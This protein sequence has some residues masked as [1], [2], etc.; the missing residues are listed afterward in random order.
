MESLKDF[1]T[2]RDA[3]GYRLAWMSKAGGKAFWISRPG[4]WLEKYEVE[5]SSPLNISTTEYWGEKRVARAGVYIT[6]QRQ[7]LNTRKR[8]ELWQGEIVRPFNSDHVVSLNL[9]R[10]GNTVRDWLDFTNK[11]GLIG[12][13]PTLGR[14]FLSGKD[15]R[16]FIAETEHEGE[17]HH[18]RNVLFRVYEYYPAIQNRDFAFL[19]NFITWE[20]DDI[21]RE[22]IG[23][24]VGGIKITPAIAMR[25][26][27][28]MNARYFEVMSKPDVF[29]P[30]AIAIKDYVNSYL[31]K[32]LSLEISFDPKT[33]QFIS[34]LQFGSFGAALVA[35][36]V[37]LVAGRLE[38]RACNV[39]GTWFRVGANHKRKDR[40]F[41]SPACKMRDYR[42]RKS[43]NAAL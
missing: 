12:R 7:W 6:G 25:E 1:E 13:S 15:K 20:S 35:E 18:L 26:K 33:L 2:V 29:V 41:C 17:W 4:D 23:L 40:I 34:S 16:T 43:A 9:L 38:A 37:E 8:D 10:A 39:C 14:W 30:A 31:E 22:D 19:K 28:G 3:A 36:A 42:A 24:K 5:R 21:V 11:Y 27:H 32:S